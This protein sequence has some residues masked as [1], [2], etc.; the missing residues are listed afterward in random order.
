MQ[1]HELVTAS[2]LWKVPI[3]SIFGMDIYRIPRKQKTHFVSGNRKKQEN[4]RT[5]LISAGPARS[6]LQGYSGRKLGMDIVEMKSV[7]GPG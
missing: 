3:V 1:D 5:Q 2:N 7:D 6:G 4:H